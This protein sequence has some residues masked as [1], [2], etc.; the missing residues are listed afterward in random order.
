MYI[1]W[2]CF[3]LAID[4]DRG[5]PKL[6]GRHDVVVEAESGVPDLRDGQAQA[7]ARQEKALVGGLVGACLLGGDEVVEG[8]ADAALGF[9]D[10]LVVRVRN[11]DRLRQL[12]EPKKGLWCVGE[13][14]SP[15]YSVGEF[16]KVLL[17]GGNLPGSEG[18]AHRL[19][20][21]CAI[22]TVRLLDG[23]KLGLFPVLLQH[24]RVQALEMVRGQ[25]LGEK[26]LDAALPIEERAVAVESHRLGEGD[27]GLASAG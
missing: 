6:G 5:V 13:R 14:R 10:D 19:A 2:P 15:A 3:A 1:P 16:L 26:V 23:D 12:L 4:P 18:H 22:G 21:H 20:Q 8:D 7:L 25:E 11:K 9:G 24:A 17:G 27:H